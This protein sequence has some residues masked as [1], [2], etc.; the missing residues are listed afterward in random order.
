MRGGVRIPCHLLQFPALDLKELTQEFQ[1]VHRNKETLLH[2]KAANSLLTQVKPF[3][4]V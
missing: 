1:P 4:V 3:G 2:G